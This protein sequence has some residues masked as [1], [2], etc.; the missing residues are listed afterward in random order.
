MEE[1]TKIN[2]CDEGATLLSEGI[3]RMAASDY[4][5][6]WMLK[7]RNA[8]DAIFTSTLPKKKKGDKH[9]Y[10]LCRGGMNG[11]KGSVDD[12]IRRIEKYIK[13]HPLIAHRADEIINGLRADALAERKIVGGN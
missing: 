5:Y 7:A 11:L 12:N 4:R 6:C 3:L 10:I 2:L 1:K 8:G 9:R 13:Y